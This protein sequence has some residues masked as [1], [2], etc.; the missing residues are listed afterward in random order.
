MW[1]L[2]FDLDYPMHVVRHDLENVLLHVREMFR[3]LLPAFTYDFAN[4][5]QPHLSIHN[6]TKNMLAIHGTNGDEILARLGV[7]KSMQ[8]D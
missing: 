5:R 3:Y 6:V 7:I 8:T 1:R 2:F 4:R